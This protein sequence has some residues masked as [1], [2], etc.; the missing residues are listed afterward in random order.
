M[1]DSVQAASTALIQQE[2]S[3]SPPAKRTRPDSSNVDD[4]LESLLV[5]PESFFSISLHPLLLDEI[6]GNLRTGCVVT[7]RI[8]QTGEGSKSTVCVRDRIRMAWRILLERAKKTG[9][10]KLL[11]EVE[12]LLSMRTDDSVEI[13]EACKK[14]SSATTSIAGAEEGDWLFPL[15]S[16][17]RKYA[18]LRR[19][20]MAMYHSRDGGEIFDTLDV[21]FLDLLLD[22]PDIKDLGSRLLN[23]RLGEI[24]EEI[25]ST[26]R[27]DSEV[28]HLRQL[29][30]MIA[31]ALERAGCP[32][33]PDASTK[34]EFFRQTYVVPERTRQDHET[35]VSE[36]ERLIRELDERKN[37]KSKSE[38]CHYTVGGKIKLPYRIRNGTLL[39]T[40]KELSYE[41]FV[42]QKKVM[43]KVNKKLQRKFFA[44]ISRPKMHKCSISNEALSQLRSIFFNDRGCLRKSI[45]NDI[46][47]ST[48]HGYINFAN[49][50]CRDVRND[51][52]WQ[53]PLRQHSALKNVPTRALVE[54]L[55]AEHGCIHPD[56]EVIHDLGI[57]IGGTEDQ[58]IHHDIPRQTTSWLPEDPETSEKDFVGVPVNGWEYDRAAYNEAMAC[59]YAPSSVLLGMG[60]SGTIQV[61]VQKNQI[62]RNG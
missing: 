5:V 44:G 4:G 50:S 24:E 25:G 58:S 56:Y 30:R 47:M 36:C 46:D 45:V 14:L 52:R 22:Q 1:V 7:T 2:D 6:P 26:R 53:V 12:Y 59:P 15:K 62:D 18:F 13:L 60:D 39:V 3:L 57:L 55:L 17:L 43:E 38:I 31:R 23:L 28:T 9:T 20:A 54:A 35:V 42:S 41:E 48:K 61:G 10:E 49:A 51:Y 29:S 21:S 27:T 34:K 32:V 8:P 19:L 16:P 40:E 33:A 11:R 37:L